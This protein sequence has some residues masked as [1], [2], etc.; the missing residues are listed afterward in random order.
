MK[1]KEIVNYFYCDGFMTGNSL[2][3]LPKGESNS[4]WY[5]LALVTDF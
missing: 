3:F 1:I 2:K 5:K 4:P